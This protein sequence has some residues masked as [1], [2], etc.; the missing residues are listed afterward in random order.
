MSNPEIF[1]QVMIPC[2]DI[3]QKSIEALVTGKPDALILG[4]YESGMVPIIL[5]SIIRKATKQ[6]IAVFGIRS[7]LFENASIE[8][9]NGSLPLDELYVMQPEILHAGLIP[10]QGYPQGVLEIADQI[11]AN[12]DTIS[13]F[14]ITTA[15]ITL[16]HPVMTTYFFE[17]IKNIFT[18][19]TAYEERITH[20]RK[21]FSSDRFNA[22]I[23][24]VLAENEPPYG[25]FSHTATTVRTLYGF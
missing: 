17:G 9:V 10:L 12:R 5:E 24:A 2:G 22:R 23:D 6:R 16:D 1:Y 25:S 21:R 18:K 4:T 8:L 20:V 7:C 13:N 3:L 11:K 19:Y 14:P 15:R